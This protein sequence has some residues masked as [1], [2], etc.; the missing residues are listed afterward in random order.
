LKIQGK[1]L[2]VVTEPKLKDPQLVMDLGFP[3]KLG[4]V[5]HPVI[6][7]PWIGRLLL[8]WLIIVAVA[9]IFRFATRRSQV[10]AAVWLLDAL[11]LIA[12]LYL[13]HVYFKNNW[14]N[15]VAFVKAWFNG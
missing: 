11:Y 13:F 8:E 3:L 4:C 12:C 2:V 10:T 7:I 14:G 9:V 5:K 1:E 6:D 15:T